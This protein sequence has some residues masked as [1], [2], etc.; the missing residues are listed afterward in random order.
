MT[1]TDTFMGRCLRGAAVPAEINAYVE[2]WH[3]G[4]MGEGVALHD[5]LGLNPAEYG[6]WMRDSKAIYAILTERRA[7]ARIPDSLPFRS[8]PDIEQLR[9][10]VATVR[11]KAEYIGK[12]ADGEPQYVSSR[13]KPV[14]TFRGTAKL[15]GTNCG[16]AFNLLSGEVY[17]QS[18]E[19]ILSVE[20]DNFGFTAWLLSPGAAEDRAQLRDAILAA[21]AG[22]VDQQIIACRVFGEWCGP[23]VNAK[24]AIGQLPQRWVVF[25]ALVTLADGTEM[26]FSSENIIAAWPGERRA[27][28]LLHFIAD[29]PQWSIDIDFNNPEVIL[30]ELERLTLEVEAECPVAKALGVTGIGE[31]IV[32]TYSDQKHG[33]LW[34]K[35]KGTKHKGTKNSRLVQIEPEVLAS[36]D[37]FTDAVVTASRMEQGFELIRA[38]Q[39]QV[40]ETHIG[41]FLKWVG[42]DV[43]KEESDTLGAS[44][45][46][47][48]QVMGR[49]NQRAKAW[50]MPRLA[51]V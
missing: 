10:A 30:D 38:N 28:S 45:L 6:R 14:L 2:Q 34:F 5:L 26:W 19:R 27:G 16:A 8:F 20:N 4:T 1:C 29:Y 36:L 17:G 3:E 48:K 24:T 25:S 33:R 41:E 49:V 39:G 22:A 23:L 47:R 44:G 46:E 51:R 37:A 31:G 15:H 42:Q 21:A 12:G 35:T 43:L 18:R 32:W 7:A 13:P 9:H 40:N 50:L 11:H